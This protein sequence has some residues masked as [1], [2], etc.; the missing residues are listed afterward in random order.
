V[1]A[2]VEIDIADV[3]AALGPERRRRR[4]IVRGNATMRWK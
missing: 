1:A 4:E 2:I 3:V